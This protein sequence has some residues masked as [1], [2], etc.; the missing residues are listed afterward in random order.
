MSAAIL[1]GVP[2]TTLD[3]DI[4]LDLPA[5]AYL[6]IHEICRRLGATPLAPTAVALSDDSLV[7]FLFHVDGLQ[8]F[9]A[10]S[11]RALRLRWLGTTVAV[12]PLAQIIKSK[13]AVQRPKDIAH[14]PLLRQT[15]QLQRR[16]RKK[17]AS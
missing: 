2:A 11:K 14:L 7:N 1:Q 15:L 16:L 4:W 9:A 10:E 3:T 17:P 5:R 6:R 8:S 12:M 13:Q